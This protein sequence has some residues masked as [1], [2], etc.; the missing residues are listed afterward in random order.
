VLSIEDEAIMVAFRQ[1][2]LSPLDDCP[3]AQQAAL[4]HLTQSS[5]PAAPRQLPPA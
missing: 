5:L 3:Y 1:H 4:P 2:K